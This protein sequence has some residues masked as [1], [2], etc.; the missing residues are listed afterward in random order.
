[1]ITQFPGLI[2]LTY[3]FEIK[4]T[5]MT[6]QMPQTQVIASVFSTSDR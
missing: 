4:V 2:L 5:V 3:V 1:M 6:K